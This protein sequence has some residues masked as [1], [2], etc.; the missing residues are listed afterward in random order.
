MRPFGCPV[1][2]LN[3]L[4]PLGKFDGKADEGFL[5]GYSIN[6][7]AF[8]VFNTRTR[9]LEEN[10]HIT[11]LEYK[12]NVAGSGPYWLFDIDL[13]T[14]S[15]Y[16]EP[17]TS[18]EDAVADDAGKKTTEELAN[19]AELDKLLVQQ[20]EGYANNTNRVSIVSPSVSAAGQSFINADDLPTDP[21]IPDLEDTTDL[22][23][24][25]IFSGAYDDEDVG[26]EADLNNLE[27]TINVSPIP[28]TRIHKDHPKDQIIGDINSATQTRRMTK[29]SKEH[30]MT[31]VDLPNAK[32]AIGTKWV[33]RNKK[34]EIGIVVKNKARLVAQGYTQEE[35]IDYDEF[36]APVARI[37]AIG[38]F[39]AYATFMGFIMYQMDV[40]SAFLYGTIEEE[41]YVCQPLSFEDPQFPNKVYKVEKALYGLHQ[42][43][44]A[45]YETLST[46]L[47]ENVFRRGTID[48][49]LFIKKDK[50]D[51]QEIPDEFYEGAHFLLRLADT[52]KALLKDEEVEDVDV[53]LYRS[54]IGSMMYLT[55]SRPDIMF[56]VCAYARFQVTPKVSHLHAVKRIFRYLKGQPKLGLWY[57]GDSPFNL[58]AFSDSD[59]AGA[60]LDRK[61]TTGG[62][63]FLGKRLISWQCKKQTVVANST[64]KAEY[65]ATANCYGQNPAL[66]YKTKHIEIRHHFIRDSYEKRLIQ[67][68]KIHTDHKVVDLLTKAFDVSSDEFG[69]K[70]G[71]CKVN[72]ARQDLV[73][74]GKISTAEPKLVLFVTVGDNTAEGV[75]SKYNGFF[76]SRSDEN[77]E[78]H[79]IV[80][81]L[82]TSS[83]HYALTIS[84]TIYA[85]YIEQFWATA[86]SKTVNDVTQI[87]TQLMARQWY[88]VQVVDPGDKIPHWGVQMLRLGGHT[89]G[90]DEGRPN[91]NEL[92]NLCTQL[93]NRVLALENSK[94]AQDLVIQKLKKR[95]KR[96]EKALRLPS[97]WYLRER[98]DKENVS[99]QGRKS[100]K[101]KPMFNDSDFDVLDDAMENVK[102]GSTAKQITTVGDNYLILLVSNE[103]T[104]I[105]DTLVAIRSA[106]PRTTSVM[107]HNVEEEPR[108]ATL[109]QSQDKGKGKMVEP[110]PTPKNPRKAQIQMD[111]EPAQRKNVLNERTEYPFLMSAVTEEMDKKMEAT[112]LNA[113]YMSEK[114]SKHS[115]DSPLPGVKTPR[116]DEERN[117]QQDLTDFVPPTPHDSP[118]S[119]GHT[120]GSDKDLVIQQLKKRVKR[121]EKALRARTLGMKLFKIS[122]SKRKGLDKENVSKQGR[123]SDKTKPM[124]NDSDFDVLDDAMENVEGGS[125]AEQI[126]T[127]VDILNTASI[128]ISTVRPSNV[129][130]AGPSNVSA[131]SPS[132]S[133][134][135]DIFEDEMTTI[136]NTLVAIRSARPRTTSVMIRNVEK[137]PM[138]AIPKNKHSLRK[139]KGLLGKK[140]QKKEAKD[141]ALIK[142]IEDVQ[143]RMDAEELLAERIQ[144]EE[145][146][147]F[148]VDEQ[149]RMLVDLIAERKKFF[150]L[151]K[152]EQQWINDFVPISDDSRKKDDS[153][154]KQA[155]SSKKRPRA[156][157]DEESVKKHKLE[158]E[159]EREELKACLDIVPGDDIAM[160]FESLAIKYLIIDW[161]IHIL[162]EDMMY[163][164]IIKADGSFKNYKIFSGMLDDFDRQDVIDLYRSK[165]F[166]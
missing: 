83:I 71:S 136:A 163:Y 126:T 87:H 145:R 161:K 72:A 64:T 24:T 105:A 119:G 118:L 59:Y 133:T 38:L 122:T 92:I 90:S 65:V 80:D 143:A 116:S 111:E 37:E 41:V 2:I 47:L 63:Q 157:H 52:N 31:L 67:V 131:A 160:D 50:Y 151:Y 1:T 86:K 166:I 66:H 147:Q 93:S 42:A 153:S 40:K 30:A 98:L 159:A 102:G 106:R 146:E 46:Y 128:S 165:D 138:R 152:K 84:P 44:R 45:S 8:R 21:L 112:L 108:R 70:T 134:A 77:A 120:P 35:G 36:F 117:E 85:S 154:S 115:Y 141:T 144:Q 125:T 107:I 55:A 27:T 61:S 110:E 17:V 78:F 103:M 81:F 113:I 156:K 57:P 121:L 139:S 9:K 15:M 73:L 26:A 123:K 135:G 53:H 101:T 91:F 82:T 29:I 124:F 140:L 99:K 100:D 149:A 22:L 12:P 89:P 48:K 28:T 32:R 10:L 14:N 158:D 51:A 132:T 109:V 54:M 11:F 127:V 68:I 19:E 148:T 164:Q 95:V 33:F 104:T 20:K 43:P 150:K 96:L 13:L 58:E 7:K 18:S 75:N 129:S 39:L 76:A 60:S 49:T 137:E 23:N 4:D 69:V 97:R 79:Q 3:T 74:M 6:I 162:T 142:Q 16:Y 88:L 114:A 130:T 155:K 62:C 25:G 5:V 94:T 34:D 56:V